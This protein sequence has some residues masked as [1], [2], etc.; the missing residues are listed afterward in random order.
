MDEQFP[1]ANI[2]GYE[3]LIGAITLPDADDRHVLAAA[4]VSNVDAIVTF[5]TKDFPQECVAQYEL[6]IIDADDFVLGQFEISLAAAL[7]AAKNCRANLK[8]PPKT[9]DEY[10]DTLSKHQ[11]PQTASELRRYREFI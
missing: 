10:I 3:G 8:H 4:I 1:D 7:S 9:A 11:L 2:S 5:N 6:E